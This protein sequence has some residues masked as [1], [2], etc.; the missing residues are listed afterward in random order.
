MT[1][2][3]Q[4]GLDL[5]IKKKGEWQYAGVG[6]PQGIHSTSTLAENMDTSEKD[7]I[8]YL[9]L[10]DEI[11]HLEIGVSSDAYLKKNKESL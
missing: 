4:K 11:T 6:I 2:I 10:Y 1:P 8:L 7:C 9:P 3:M 5:Y